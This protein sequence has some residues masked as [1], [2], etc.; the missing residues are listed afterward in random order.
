[1]TDVT[2]ILSKAL[3]AYQ[4]NDDQAAQALCQAVLA[5]S[6]ERADAWTLLGMVHKREGRIDEALAAYE[7]AL[8]HLPNYAEAHNNIGNIRRDQRRT[9]D[10]IDCYR[11]ALQ[12]DP[13]SATAWHNLG[14]L[15]DQHQGKAT[16][17]LRCF[18]QALAIDP[19][20]PNIHWD[21]ALALL[22]L[23]RFD[24]GFKAYESRWQRG[25]PAPRQLKEPPWRG[26]ALDGKTVLVYAEQGFGDALQFIRFLPAVTAH[27]GRIVLEVQSALC[28]LMAAQPG[29]VSVT[30]A[31]EALPAFDCHVALMS[32]PYII[33]AGHAKLLR[34]TPYLNAPPDR[35]PAWRKRI[36]PEPLLRVGLVWGGNPNVKN[37]AIRS[38][39]LQPLRPL[40]DVPGVRFYF[41]Q[42]GPRREDL[43]QVD[44]PDG[45]V[46]LDSAIQD[47]SDTAAAIANLDLVI[48]SDTSVAHLSGA[49]STP[50]WLLAQCAPDWRW[51]LQDGTAP[52]WYPDARIFRQPAAGRWDSV[53]AEVVTALTSLAARAPNH[54]SSIPVMV[55]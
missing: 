34:K 52:C 10:S 53:V 45:Y 32:I 28:S 19:G 37:D 44:L 51:A 46:D 1:M 39:R 20:N 41:L 25:Q 26:E 47:F 27:G 5:Q 2:T 49:L 12:C 23:G 7:T 9:Q 42:K 4:Q 43:T 29:I 13:K 18:D 14:T 15:L 54:P 35:L 55:R 30:A 38:P 31:G 33:G 48:S 17:A 36:P 24:E 6:P 22:S 21:R 11:R 50:L 16:E 3:A 8:T 40:F